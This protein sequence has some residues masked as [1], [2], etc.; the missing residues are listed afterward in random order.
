MPRGMTK[1]R[2]PETNGNVQCATL[3]P[4]C[5]QSPAE[6]GYCPSHSATEPFEGDT[7]VLKN[8]GR[9]GLASRFRINCA[10]KVP[11]EW[12]PQGTLS[13]GR[14]QSLPGQGTL[15]GA[16]PPF[17]GLTLLVCF[18]VPQ[19]LLSRQH[20]PSFSQPAGAVR[21]KNTR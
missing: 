5:A 2:V 18:P 8:V 1:E 4:T 17:P 6:H 13:P 16:L 14:G 3:F 10:R 12:P 21:G 9:E 11:V 19:F 20:H 7:R 15:S